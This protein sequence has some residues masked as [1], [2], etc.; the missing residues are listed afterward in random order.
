MVLPVLR[1]A[2]FFV[3]G[4]FAAA[5]LVLVV[6]PTI[7]SDFHTAVYFVVVSTTT[8]GYGDMSPK[9]IGI[10]SFLICLFY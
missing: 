4:I 10:V 8:L 2:L 5:C 1:V 9:T 3:V 6:E 7:V